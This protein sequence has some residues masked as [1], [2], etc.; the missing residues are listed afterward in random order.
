MKIHLDQNPSDDDIQKVVDGLMRYGLNEI[1]NEKPTKCA[2]V[3]KKDDQVIGGAVCKAHVGQFYLDYLWVSEKYRSNGYG[4]LLHKNVLEMAKEHKTS[5]IWVQTLNP[6]A[7]LFYKSTGY[8]EIGVIP[9]YV[10][11]FNLHHLQ[12]KF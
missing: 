9:N 11:G 2:L 5:C 4:S 6:R 3:L 7:V 1:N 8:N 12:L 10:E